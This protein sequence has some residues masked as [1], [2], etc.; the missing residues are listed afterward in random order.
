MP[1]NSPNPAQFV[2]G[3]VD[4]EY[5]IKVLDSS[6]RLIAT[7][8]IPGVQSDATV[9]VDAHLVGDTSSRFVNLV[10][11][12][13]NTNTASY[14]RFEVDPS[15]RWF[16]LVRLDSGT[17]VPL[18]DWTPSAAI[19]AQTATNTLEM[20]CIGETISASIN[21]TKVASVQGRDLSTGTHVDRPVEPRSDR[22]SAVR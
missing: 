1:K 2:R 7:A 22:R 17:I 20:S 21:G 13:Q 18:V 3:Y 19:L 9:T 15:R 5:Q 10:C 6:M 8:F 16:R 12:T 14:Y 4:G 11:R